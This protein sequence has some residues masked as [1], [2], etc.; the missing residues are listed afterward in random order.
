MLDWV[1]KGIDIKI[2][3][4]LGTGLF[5][6]SVVSQMTAAEKQSETKDVEGKTKSK[7]ATKAK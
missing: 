4:L 7:T 6:F 1:R 2:L 5:T 3:F